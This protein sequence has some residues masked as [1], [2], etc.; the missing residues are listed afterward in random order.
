MA[1]D[2]RHACLHCVPTRTVIGHRVAIEPGVIDTLR[3]ETPLADPKPET[4]RAF[5]LAVADMRDRLSAEESTPRGG[6]P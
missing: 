5:A 2:A 4:L 1:V 6:G 3:D